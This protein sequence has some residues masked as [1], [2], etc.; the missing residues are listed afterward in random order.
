MDMRACVTTQGKAVGRV[1]IRG[2]GARGGTACALDGLVSECM[3][4][5]MHARHQTGRQ[6]AEPLLAR[7]RAY[8]M[9]RSMRT[10]AAACNST[11]ATCHVLYSPHAPAQACTSMYERRQHSP[12]AQL[13]CPPHAPLHSTLRAPPQSPMSLVSQ[14]E[15]CGVAAY[16]GGSGGAEGEGGH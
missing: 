9:T 14:R 5:W 4:R 3:D 7:D 10:A 1:H 13:G 16:A 15:R 8:S 6:S 12:H 11:N 2:C